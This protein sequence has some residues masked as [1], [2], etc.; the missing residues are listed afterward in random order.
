MPGLLGRLGIGR[1]QRRLELG[2]Q[3]GEQLAL[4]VDRELPGLL[5][6]GLGERDDQVDH[7]L[8]LLLAEQH[9][10]QHGL[11]GQ[12][13]GFGLDHHHRVA[14]PG[15][16]QIELAARQLLERR[17]EEELAVPIAD[18]G[19]R[20][21]PEKRNA[22][23]GQ[24]GARPDHRDDVRVVLLVVREHRADHL[25]LVP[26]AAREQRPD[27]PVDQARGQDLLLRRTALAL[28]EAA[29]D[30]ARGEGLLLI[31][32]GQREEVLPRLDLAL[33]DRG[34]QHRG[35]A[36]G[37]EHRAIGLPREAAT[38]QNQRATAPDDLFSVDLKH[39]FL[40]LCNSLDRRSVAR[41]P[42]RIDAGPAGMAA[43]TALAVGRA[44]AR[45][46]ERYR[47]K[48]RRSIKA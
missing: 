7:R 9:R 5:C 20:D 48:P 29:G 16:D 2:L 22:R 38:L 36:V 11:L 43:A 6:A 33:R 25:G 40:C 42:V 47:R 15:H 21:R 17:V 32:D 8:E 44:A 31:V 37:G 1:P 39:C 34:A 35:L 27:R 12:L 41:R 23:D 3:L 28:E 18:A 26:E 19:A 10:L 14:G 30:L 46:R 45:V 4:V 24:G 13:L